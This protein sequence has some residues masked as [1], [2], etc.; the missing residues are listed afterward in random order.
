MGALPVR[1]GLHSLA[2]KQELLIYVL[3]EENR[4]EAKNYSNVYPPTNLTVD[5]VVKERMGE[6]YAG[7]HD[8]LL[9]KNKKGILVE[10]AWP[11]KGCG[12][13][14][15]NEALLPHELMSLGGDV[16]ELGLPEEEAHPEPPELSDK[17]KEQYEAKLKELPATEK[18]EFK[19]TFEKER[20]EVA[21]RK[22]L[23]ARN[24]YVITRL[25]H[26]YDASNLPEDIA[27]KKAEPLAGG[28]GLPKG[29]SH[30]LSTK[31]NRA[32]ENKFQIRYNFFH[33][34]EGMQKCEKPERWRWGK[35]PRTYRGLRKIWVAVDLA[36]KKRKQIIPSKVVQTPVPELGL[37]GVVEQADAGADAGKPG[38]KGDKKSCGCRA[39]G[40]PL[41]NPSGFWF[42]ALALGLAA[43]RRV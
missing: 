25:H 28:A 41:E 30:K 17:E 9:A 27:L 8:M 11:S 18:K 29:Q 10:Y 43:R 37:S 1:L 3:D 42:F 36:R 6:F 5:F 39:V 26:R 33:P 38:N 13:P 40:A 32:K 23:I 7:L 4:Y 19:E 31:V 35:P 21:R 14:C 34:W 12:E 16:F 15:Q 2:K 22:A 24:R 20:K